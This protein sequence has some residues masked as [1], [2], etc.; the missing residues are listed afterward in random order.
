MSSKIYKSYKG[1]S[2]SQNY[3]P[4]HSKKAFLDLLGIRSLLSCSISSSTYPFFRQK[5]GAFLKK[6]RGLVTD[7]GVVAETKVLMI[8]LWSLDLRSF[9]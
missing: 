9:T 2:F 3:T 4:C 8:G 1:P 7:V 5:P 6:K